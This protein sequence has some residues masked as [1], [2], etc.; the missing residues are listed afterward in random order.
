MV[1]RKKK[2]TK[3]AS[4]ASVP[5]KVEK[6]RKKQHQKQGLPGSDSEEKEVKKKKCRK[7]ALEGDSAAEEKR[8]GKCQKQAPSNPAQHRGSVDQ[9][10]INGS[11]YVGDREGDH[12]ILH[13]TKVI[14]H[15]QV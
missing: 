8:K 9:T 13:M 15:H 4:L 10:G 3:K 1:E 14:S 11:M 7:R 5:T 12:L 6:K 2:H